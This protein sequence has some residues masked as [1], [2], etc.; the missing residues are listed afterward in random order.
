MRGMRGLTWQGAALTS[1]PPHRLPVA[2]PRSPLKPGR[3]SLLRGVTPS[4]ATVVV[5]RQPLLFDE[6]VQSITVDMG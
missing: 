6:L 2:M 3:D 1:K 4:T 5:L